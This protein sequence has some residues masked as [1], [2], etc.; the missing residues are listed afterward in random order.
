MSTSRTIR[1]YIFVI[2]SSII[3]GFMPLMAK[4]IYENGVNPLTL[5][6][7]RNLLSLPAIAVIAGIKKETLSIK[8]N[9]ILPLTITTFFGAC[10]TSVLLFTSYQHIDTGTAT[11]FHFVYP[12]FVMLLEAFVLKKVVTRNNLV[13]L[14]LCIIGICLFYTPGKEI[15]FTGSAIA[16]LSGV[17]YAIYIMFL[18]ILRKKEVPEIA[19]NFYLSLFCSVI[20]LTLCCLSGKLSLPHDLTGWIYTFLF[21]TIIN[22]GAVTLFQ[23][24]TF[25][26]GGQRSSILSTFEP[27]VS[28]LVGYAILNEKL[29]MA[30]LAGVLFVLTSVFV[31]LKNKN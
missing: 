14:M 25:V 27:A 5:V 7:L 22:A 11:V 15:N 24:G 1:G 8:K 28:V 3:Y 30:S 23:H 13:G 20:M 2:T 26:I 10:L 21:A 6:L 19:V 12:A 16:L 31:I 17:T 29:T 18:T 4:L 9:H